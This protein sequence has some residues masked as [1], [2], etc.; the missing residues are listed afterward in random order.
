MIEDL[1]C[2]Y[3]HVDVSAASNGAGFYK[4]ITLPFKKLV[5]A[6]EYTATVYLVLS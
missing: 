2:S 3:L 4:K 1:K 5:G 6:V